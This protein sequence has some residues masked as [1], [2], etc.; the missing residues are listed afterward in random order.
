MGDGFEP[1]RLP[2]GE[3][4]FLTL[5]GR[6]VGPTWLTWGRCVLQT[7]D[8]RELPIGELSSESEYSRG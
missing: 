8:G 4:E 3:F 2:D 7:T 5:A 1:R 6:S